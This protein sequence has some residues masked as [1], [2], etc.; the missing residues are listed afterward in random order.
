MNDSNAS[1]SRPVPTLALPVNMQRLSDGR[2]YLDQAATLVPNATLQFSLGFVLLYS[3]H[4]CAGSP[5]FA[6]ASLERL[7]VWPLADVAAVVVSIA[8]VAVFL[9]SR[10]GLLS[11]GV[12][13]WIFGAFEVLTA[14]GV[15]LFETW[16]G[17]TGVDSVRGVPLVCL[18]IIVF[19]LLVSSS[20]G[21]Q[22]LT[23]VLAGLSF[24]LAIWAGVVWN[25]A[26]MGDFG[27]LLTANGTVVI[28]VVLAC[29]PSSVVHDNRWREELSTLGNYVLQHKLGSGGMG[30]VWQ[31]EHRVLKR[32][33]AVK[34]I[35]ASKS[36]WSLENRQLR[37]RFA[38][39][40]RI[41]ATLR[42]PHTV[43]L[44]DYGFGRAGT[45]FIVMERLDGM[46]L[47]SLVSDYGPVPS[48][49]CIWF[50]RQICQSLS[51]AHSMGL[52]H[53]DVK[54]ANVHVG[55]YGEEYDVCKVLDFG[56]AM[57]PR[58][59]SGNP[60]EPDGVVLGTPAFMA[61]E[62]I[63]G[64]R[65]VDRRVDIYSLGCT[66]YWLLTGTLVFDEPELNRLMEAHLHVVPPPLSERTDAEIP[67]ALARL[68]MSCLRKDPEQ[69]PGTVR[70]VLE[71][72]DDLQLK[73]PWSSAA[74]REW[75][76]RPDVVQGT[77]GQHSGQD[78][79]AMT[80]EVDV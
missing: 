79:Y 31:A 63:Q 46:T 38:T 52:V 53:R 9:L 24:P 73:Y 65:S 41:I 58:G 76:S 14:F 6:T 43:A 45:A 10:S 17:A 15:S 19:P 37:E 18:I 75:W 5:G 16:A 74:A 28:A 27:G 57:L 34:L 80:Q 12:L 8:G 61:P 51:E 1:S 67:P 72:L 64:S 35:R 49:R 39:E 69:R 59:R 23:A 29:F 30:E 78:A 56:L 66:A 47:E 25:N 36:S 4:S 3:L 62:V 13:L 40:A 68:I 70:D 21:R 22:L 26:P 2:D 20:L 11:S 55:V 32:P 60:S 50:L 54:P 33:A 71:L 44:Y 42:S 77:P 7:P 48:E